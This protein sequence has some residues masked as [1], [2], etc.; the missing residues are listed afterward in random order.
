MENIVGKYDI[1]EKTS[2]SKLWVNY[3]EMPPLYVVS[4]VIEIL[5]DGFLED[6]PCQMAS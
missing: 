6:S 5:H 2:Q 4:K 3:V 1:W